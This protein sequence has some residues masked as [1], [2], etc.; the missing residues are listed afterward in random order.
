M[1]QGQ[2]P[3]DE[4]L[5]A[6]GPLEKTGEEQS[7]LELSSVGETALH[8]WQAP[9][10]TAEGHDDCRQNPRKSGLSS[11]RLGLQAPAPTWG[12]LLRGFSAEEPHHALGSLNH[13]PISP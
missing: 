3:M 6:K 8:I 4:L 12:G 9:C 5:I 11:I 1:G 13:P 7:N 2:L 10:C